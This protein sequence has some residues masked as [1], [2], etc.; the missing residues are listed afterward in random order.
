MSDCVS[1]SADNQMGD[2]GAT[3][4]GKALESNTTLTKLNLYS[5]FELCGYSCV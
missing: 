4:L 2:A 1:V 5:A 3:A